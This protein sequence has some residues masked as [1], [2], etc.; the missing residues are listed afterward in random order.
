LVF[1]FLLEESFETKQYKRSIY[2]GYT[3]LGSLIEAR[4]QEV[5]EA[6][7]TNPSE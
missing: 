6:P 4:M 3:A 2:V 5:K 7:E 1:F